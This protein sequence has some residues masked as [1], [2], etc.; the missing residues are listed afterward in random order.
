M[1]NIKNMASEFKD[2]L[3]KKAYNAMIGYT[4]EITD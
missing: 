2:V 3:A 4:V 1:K